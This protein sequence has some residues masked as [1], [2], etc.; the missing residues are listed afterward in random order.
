MQILHEYRKST[1]LKADSENLYQSDESADESG[2]NLRE[3]E[4]G[5]QFRSIMEHLVGSGLTDYEILAET[6]TIFIAVRLSSFTKCSYK[7]DICMIRMFRFAKN[8]EVKL[9]LGQ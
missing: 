4:K 8:R 2:L 5:S 3:S 9:H 6:Y 7:E 1:S